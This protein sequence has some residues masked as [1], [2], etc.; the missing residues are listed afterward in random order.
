MTNSKSIR[1]ASWFVVSGLA[2]LFAGTLSSAFIYLE[3]ERMPDAAEYRIAG[4]Q[5]YPIQIEESKQHIGELQMYGGN[6]AVI[7]ASIDHKLR[8]MFK[9]RKLAGLLLMSSIVLTAG[10][11]A[12]AWQ[13]RR[14]H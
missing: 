2:I 7:I 5:T 10:C 9:G 4:S 13:L 8:D 6:A 12:M 11:F 14:K 3:P 1:P